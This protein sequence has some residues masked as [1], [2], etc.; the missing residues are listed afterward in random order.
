MWPSIKKM[1]KTFCR[2]TTNENK[3]FSHKKQGY[4]NHTWSEK[5]FKGTVVNKTCHSI[6]GGSRLQFL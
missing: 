1:H 5:D 2:E 6:N 3:Q 4:I